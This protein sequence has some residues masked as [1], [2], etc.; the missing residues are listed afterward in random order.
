MTT[1]FK[2]RFIRYGQI[3]DN[4]GFTLIELLV[5]I[6]IIGILSA[7]ALPSFF[8]QANQAKQTEARIYVGTINRA[9]QAYRLENPEFA[10]TSASL[11]A[12]LP[13]SSK[14]YTYTLSTTPSAFATFVTGTSSDPALKAYIGAVQLVQSTTTTEPIAVSILCE[15]LNPGT[16]LTVSALENYSSTALSTTNPV[17]KDTVAKSLN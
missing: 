3:H 16:P 17:C 1:E 12:G 15:A 5:V 9:Q 14:G 2:I 4:S 7:I 10:T 6:V 13:P 11:G 8:R